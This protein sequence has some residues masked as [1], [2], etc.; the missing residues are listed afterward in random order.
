[1]G[2]QESDRHYR[3]ESAS[4][5]LE[6]IHSLARQNPEAFGELVVK[7][8][9]KLAEWDRG[10]YEYLMSGVVSRELRAA[11]LLVALEQAKQALSQGHAD[12]V[13]ER[14]SAIEGWV[15][16]IEYLGSQE[17]LELLLAQE[18][19]PGAASPQTYLM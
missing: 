13:E 9:C 3:A 7:I 15:H 14:V 12:R 6:S 19:K 2:D 18:Q 10:A 1:M 17:R 11:G 5:I 8:L 16:A 4:A